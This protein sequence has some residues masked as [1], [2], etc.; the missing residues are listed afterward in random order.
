MKTILKGMTAAAIAAL[1]AVPASAQSFPSDTVRMIVPW[2]AGG[3]TDLIARALAAAMEK[4]AGAT[5]IVDNISGASGATGSLNV[6]QGKP[7]G[8]TLLLN[9]S[10]DLT[11]LLTF[12]KLPFTLDDFTYVGGV[13]ST[14]T[15][16]VSHSDRGYG[17]LDA[18]REAAKA[19]PGE[20]TIGVGGAVGAHAL[21]A[22][23][24]RGYAEMDVRVI[25]YQGGAALNKALLANEV[26]AGVIHSPILLN[27]V[28]EG[29]ID[30]LATGGALTGIS[31]EPLRSTKTLEDFGIPVE[32]GV[33]RGL[34][35]PKGTP[36]EV[37]AR[38]GEI[39][40]AATESDSFKAF[41]EKFGFE[42]VWLDS[43]AFEELVRGELA[44]FGEIQTKFIR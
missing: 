2:A 40:K 7:D 6:A 35:A 27:E 1:L 9:G 8:Y 13:Y 16:M 30:V 24:I 20:L 31:H 5:I 15:W 44:T 23:A 10:S 3:G 18:F 43:A 41:G 25:A 29:M 36:P 34:F 32:V 37:I 12:Q 33:V 14:P 38:L 11:A 42:P 28:K 21:M 19:K 39:A 22:H 26:D 17:D 4:P